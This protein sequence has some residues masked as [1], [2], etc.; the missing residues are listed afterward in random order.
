VSSER[1][2]ARDLGAENDDDKRGVSNPRTGSGTGAWAQPGGCSRPGSTA[3]DGGRRQ[4][5]GT[6]RR[7]VENDEDPQLAGVQLLGRRQMR[8]FFSLRG[9]A[10]TVASAFGRQPPLFVAAP[11]AASAVRP[12]R[13]HARARSCRSWPVPAPS[14]RLLRSDHEAQSSGHSQ[15]RIDALCRGSRGTCQPVA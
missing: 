5:R 1:L 2:R 9:G 13:A 6:E 3:G 12:S 11:L 7:A 8:R 4:S 10:A 14:R 15:G